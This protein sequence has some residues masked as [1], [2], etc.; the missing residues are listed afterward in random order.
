MKN[1]RAFAELARSKSTDPT[2]VRKPANTLAKP[3][4]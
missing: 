1:G 2:A 3:A 4:D